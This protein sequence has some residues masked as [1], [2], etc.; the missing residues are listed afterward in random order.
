MDIPNRMQGPASAFSADY[1]NLLRKK[2]EVPSAREAERAGPWKIVK[3]ASGY[4]IYR[5]W[6]SPES[7]HA[8]VVT[9]KDPQTALLVLAVLPLTGRDPVYRRVE[10]PGTQ[11]VR[12][13][14]EG[15][16]ALLLSVEDMEVVN[17]VNLAAEV[18]RS[19]LSLAAIVEASGPHT[20]EILG[21]LLREG[22]AG[23]SILAAHLPEQDRKA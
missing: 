1:L 2:D 17:A 13:E 9:C 23:G 8:P 4:G 15:D 10:T 7:G 20:Q 5:L 3:E 22:A 16:E 18:A 19:P 21:Q 6:E 11:G 12:L 14:S